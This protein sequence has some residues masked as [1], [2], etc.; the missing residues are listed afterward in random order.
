MS[1]HLRYRCRVNSTSRASCSSGT[2]RGWWARVT[3]GCAQSEGT[4][5][6]RPTSLWSGGSPLRLLWVSVAA[7][8]FTALAGCGY[9]SAPVQPPAASSSAAIA[10]A[11]SSRDRSPSTSVPTPASSSSASRSGAIVTVPLPDTS[12]PVSPHFITE[13]LDIT[14]WGEIKHTGPGWVGTIGNTTYVLLAGTIKDGGNNV[15]AVFAGG[16]N[17]P[18][19]QAQWFVQLSV[20]GDPTIA[21]VTTAGVV[22]ITTSTGQR[23]QYNVVTKGFVQ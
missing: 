13:G 16:D 15:L 7:G 14:G 5:A 6:S 2:G 17:F 12:P 20:T 23:A 19:T 22:A 18:P 1:T 9:V 21:S 3:G 8:L 10:S 4:R 11:S